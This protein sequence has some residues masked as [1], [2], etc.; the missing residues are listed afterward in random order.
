MTNHPVA[1][2]F[3]DKAQAIPRC[4]RVRE[5][6]YSSRLGAKVSRAGFVGST[7]EMSTAATPGLGSA[8]AGE[9]PRR[10]ASMRLLTAIA[11]LGVVLPSATPAST[12]PSALA[13]L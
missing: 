4:N 6:P 10:H 3:R 9:A 5:E 2:S 11:S 8:E 1:T 7:K 12:S 13:A